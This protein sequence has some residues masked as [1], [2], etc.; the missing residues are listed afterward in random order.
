MH[1]RG[2]GFLAGIT[3]PGSTLVWR[4][5]KVLFQLFIMLIQR[6]QTI[7]SNVDFVIRGAVADARLGLA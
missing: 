7:G 6:L 3:S 1:A 2:R 4:T 5:P